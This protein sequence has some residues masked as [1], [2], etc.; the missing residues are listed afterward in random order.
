M[1]KR[2]LI[3]PAGVTTENR[4]P[5][6]PSRPTREMQQRERA[7]HPFIRA[8]LL[9]KCKRRLGDDE[10]SRPT[11]PSV[12]QWRRGAFS[13]PPSHHRLPRVVT[14]ARPARRRTTVRF[15]EAA[16]SS[17]RLPATVIAVW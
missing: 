11:A 17:S 10:A 15:D 16:L 6:H 3:Q 1:W 7:G 9:P 14:V 12:P 4:P 2:L 8:D 13:E 5:I